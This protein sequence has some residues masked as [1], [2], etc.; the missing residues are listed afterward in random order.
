MGS[1]GSALAL[2]G[3][4]WRVEVKI[5]GRDSGAVHA[6]HSVVDG[7]GLRTPIIILE[8]QREDFLM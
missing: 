4:M 7:C 8:A 5:M 1:V 3:R 2:F 6:Y